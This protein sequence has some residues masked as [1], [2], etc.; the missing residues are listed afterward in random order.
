MEQ[1][2]TRQ[3][4]TW[5]DRL[6]RRSRRAIAVA[7]LVG[8]PA[9]YLWSSFWMT[10]SVSNVFWGPVAFVLIGM[11]AVGSIVL[12]WFVRDRASMPS[13]GLDERQ[14]QLRD[15]AWVLSYKVLAVAVVGVVA[16][17]AIAVLGMGRE[18]QLDGSLISAAA[19]TVG[20][21]IPI[22]PAAALAWLEPDA[23]QDA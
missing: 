22:L 5:T 1:T 9:M 17:A 15:R 23:P 18:V 11:T 4:G 12:Y 6:S 14:R 10:T 21:L 16:I 19:L 2:S 8:L 3:R 7:T 13:P 20:V